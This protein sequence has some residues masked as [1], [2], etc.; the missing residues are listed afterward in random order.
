MLTN[1]ADTEFK[2]VLLEDAMQLEQRKR[3][4]AQVVFYGERL[5]D[6]DP[7]NA[8]ALVT[9]AGETARHVREFD[10]DK[11]EKLT[12][13]RQICGRRFGGRQEHAQAPAGHPR[14]AVGKRA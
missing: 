9:L 3:D 6:A 11:E 7:K 4:F 2:I 8:F 1:F 13:G 12:K 5:L 14:R 10:L